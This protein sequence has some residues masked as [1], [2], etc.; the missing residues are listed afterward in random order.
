MARGQRTPE[1]REKGWWL[2]RMATTP[3]RRRLLRH[4]AFLAALF[5]APALILRLFTSIYPFLATVYLSLTDI[6]AFRPTPRFIGLQNYVLF[7][8]DFQLR[9]AVT[10]TILY[11]VLSTA[12]ELVLGMALALLL[13]A[14]FRLRQ[15]A[16][17]INLIP[18]VIPA[19]VTALGFRFMF[20]TDVGI[21]PDI[22]GHIGVHISWLTDP[23][24]AQAATI[25]ANVW[26]STPFVALIILAGLQGIP[27]EI[28]E[29]A[30]VDG[31]GP[32]RILWQMIIPLVTPLL[33][34]M[35]IFLLIWQ[36]GAF[37]II[38]GMT[39]GGPGSATMVLS[40]LAYQQA[41]I[42]LSFGYASAI[43]MVLF[44]CVLVVG[45]VALALF[46]RMEVSL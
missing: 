10:F 32:L 46:R 6:S 41:F 5:I 7:G 2:A 28:Y 43:S 33:V 9:Q 16:R 26:R 30:R 14:S 3:S 44:L 1:A 42:G 27:T 45:I 35:G 39:G 38:L 29:A 11:V 15:A 20:D 31:A 12:L 25:I 40:Y 19:I 22:L 34:T 23:R 17:S 13:N 18:W 24:G 8:S 37:D 4:P 36:L 21:I